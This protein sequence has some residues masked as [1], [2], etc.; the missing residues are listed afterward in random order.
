[1][2]WRLCNHAAEETF[3]AGGIKT[4]Y[5]EDTGGITISNPQTVDKAQ[6]SRLG[7]FVKRAIKLPFFRIL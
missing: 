1:M 3:P 6:G 7:F 5:Q 4:S 2:M